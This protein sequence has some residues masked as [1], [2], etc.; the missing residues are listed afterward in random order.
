[1][2]CTS[3]TRAT[4]D[5]IHTHVHALG[6]GHL[7]RHAAAQRFCGDSVVRHASRTMLKPCDARSRPLCERGCSAQ[8]AGRSSRTK[9]PART[10][11]GTQ[12]L[13]KC[14]ARRTFSLR[15]HQALINA[16]TATSVTSNS[17]RAYA[18]SSTFLLYPCINVYTKRIVRTATVRYNMFG[19]RPSSSTG[20]GTRAK[21]TPLDRAPSSSSP[22]G[23]QVV[24]TRRA[25]SVRQWRS[26]MTSLCLRARVVAFQ[27]DDLRSTDPS[28]LQCSVA[29]V[30]TVWTRCT[31]P[32]RDLNAAVDTPVA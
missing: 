29:S 4:A 7:G 22:D 10:E 13:R 11:R 27:A 8:C 1:M 24:R 3:Y 23:L 19:I 14:T 18:L 30:V 25:C 32:H 5:V 15:L 12:S 9:R 20:Y 16:A 26:G 6:P 21:T 17:S 2:C 31:R 28:C